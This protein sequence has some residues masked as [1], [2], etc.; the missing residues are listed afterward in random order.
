MDPTND[1]QVGHAWLYHDNVS[2]LLQIH[3]HFPQR[4]IRVCGI[5]LVRFFVPFAKT[6]CRTNSVAKRAVKRRRILGR[7]R[8]DHH[9]DVA[10]IVQGFSDR[11]NSSVHH[12]GRSD[13]RGARCGLV[14]GLFAQDFG[15]FVVDNV[16]IDQQAI[17]TMRCIRVESHIAHDADPS[18]E[19]LGN[20]TRRSTNKAIWIESVFRIFRL[21]VRG[22]HGENGHG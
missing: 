6:A 7:I 11:S 8:H 16:S 4:F 5:H 17:V 18:A 2:T 22:S 10:C 12:I 1:I 20:R 9:I 19:P 3:G 14:D 21:F 15:C 13:H